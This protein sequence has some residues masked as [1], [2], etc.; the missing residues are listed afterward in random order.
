MD[1]KTLVRFLRALESLGRNTN[2]MFT[3][4]TYTPDVYTEMKRDMAMMEVQAN[5]TDV[6]AYVNH[7]VRTIPKLNK[8]AR[9]KKG[10]QQD[11]VDSILGSYKGM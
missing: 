9:K 11:I 5:E 2:L 6:R 8:F 1:E 4:R 7:Q 3:S 10:L